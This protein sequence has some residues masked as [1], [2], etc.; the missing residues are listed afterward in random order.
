MRMILFA[1]ILITG[2]CA[3]GSA[4]RR[5]APLTV[6]LAAQAGCRVVDERNTKDAALPTRE[7]LCQRA[8]A[9]VAAALQKVGYELVEGRTAELG[10]NLSATLVARSD[11]TQLSVSIRLSRGGSEDL[12]RVIQQ[13]AVGASVEAALGEAAQGL[14]S[15]M[16]QSPRLREAGLVPG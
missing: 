4:P 16:R 3:T 15:E 8:H 9:A 6:N 2:A 13:V 7:D 10:A 1:T 5:S 12:E 14:T 11:G